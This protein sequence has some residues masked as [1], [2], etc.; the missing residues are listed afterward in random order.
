[1]GSDEEAKTEEEAQDGLAARPFRIPTLKPVVGGRF[2]AGATIV[3]EDDSDSDIEMAPIV[4]A[5]S[6]LV[7]QPHDLPVSCSEMDANRKATED[8]LATLAGHTADEDEENV[9]AICISGYG[10]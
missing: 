1:M 6:S 10:T 4:P 7:A 9:C 5:S 3:P 2:S 8:F